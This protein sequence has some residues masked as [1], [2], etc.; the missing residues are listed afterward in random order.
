[1]DLTINECD[2]SDI[3]HLEKDAKRHRIGFHADAQL[4]CARLDDIIVGCSAILWH[5][6][7]VL[8]KSDYVIPEKRGIGIGNAMFQYRLALVR[9][10][11]VRRIKAFCTPASL[12]MYQRY[13][14]VITRR[15]TND[16]AVTITLD[17]E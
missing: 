13:G 3:A 17:A 8:F 11:E 7:F 1:M 14:A 9:S 5:K 16:T 12:S 6:T 4:F 2:F 10:S 15:F